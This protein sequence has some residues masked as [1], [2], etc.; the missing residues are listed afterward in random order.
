MNEYDL[1]QYKSFPFAHATAANMFTLAKF[2]GYN[3][4]NFKTARV[5][6]VGCASG[7]N[8]TPQAYD[9][10]DATFCGIDYSKIQIEDGREILAKLKLNNI[11]LLH[12]SIREFETSDV[13]FDYIICHGVFSW[14]DEATQHDLLKLCQKKLS[15]NGIVYISYNTK[16]GWNA[17][18][19]VR[20]MMLY[21]SKKENTAKSRIKVSRSFL[22]KIEKLNRGKQN[23]YS[24]ILKE[25][26]AKVSKS[27]DDYFYHEYLEKDNTAFY[28]K[29]LVEK[30]GSF[31]L[32]YLTDSE[33]K[34]SYMGSYSKEVQE[35]L[36]G[37][38]DKVEL[39]QSLD[40]V[41]NRR[42]RSSLFVNVKQDLNESN[43]FD[44]FYFTTKLKMKESNKRI[45]FTLGHIKIQNASKI[46]NVALKLL[47]RRYQKPL[48]YEE[49]VR[50]VS[51]KLNME[52]VF[53]SEHMIKEMDL[54]RLIY[55]SV[56]GL[57]SDDK[58]STLI[59][60]DKPKAYEL[61]RQMAKI[62]K[63]VTN[64]YHQLVEL[65]EKDRQF[66]I[67]LDGEKKQAELISD[68]YSSDYISR[69]LKRFSENGLL[70]SS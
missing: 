70:E 23:A 41:R 47:V 64:A 13:E 14:V 35:V 7:G 5:L 53:V 32:E 27:E 33:L 3:A 68:E 43:K 69:S 1:L 49:W 10:P 29:D 48:L 54:E 4:P 56:L 42:F 28:F 6:E 21:H 17:V 38:T 34:N 63:R 12:Q 36:K 39:E 9:Y 20:D 15:E 66:F 25:E 50:M 18:Q 11:E 61:A 40:F 52:K 24:Q 60:H 58:Q 22:S 67:Y 59:I 62:S 44:N 51:E 46:T 19:T 8:L 30:V 2:L 26:L 16:P 55:L 65:K 57:H 31:G 37:I 45:I